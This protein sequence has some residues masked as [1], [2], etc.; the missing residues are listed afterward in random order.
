MKKLKTTRI[1]IIIVVMFLITMGIFWIYLK[2]TKKAG[3]NY[4]EKDVAR[5]QEQ[6]DTEQEDPE[7]GYPEVSYAG[8]TFNPHK[9][10][11]SI[12]SSK[13]F[14]ERESKRNPGMVGWMLWDTSIVQEEVMQKDMQY[15]VDHAANT[16]WT[17]VGQP[18]LDPSSNYD[19]DHIVTLYSYGSGGE[20]R[21]SYLSRLGKQAYYDQNKTFMLFYKEYLD[22]FEVDAV[23]NLKSVPGFDYTKRNFKDKKDFEDWYS[24]VKKVSTINSKLTATRKTHFMILVIQ[25]SKNEKTILVAKRLKRYLY[26]D[27]QK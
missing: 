24:V 2:N 25:T 26:R 1:Y 16:G 27:Y 3:K 6:K 4:S 10:K 19:R 7:K 21:L 20:G 23:F 18:F 9:N 8:Q 5:Q 15:Y 17:P 13:A 11:E 14:M 12:A 22:W